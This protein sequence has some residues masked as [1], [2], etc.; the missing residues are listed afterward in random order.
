MGHFHDLIADLRQPTRDLRGAIPDAM[1]G[2]GALHQGAMADGELS[3]ATKELM[4][5]AISVVL[6]CE[7]CIAYHAKGAVA[8]GATE[9][10]AAEAIGVALLMSGG[11]AT[12]YGPMA[13][14]AFRE[15]A[16]GE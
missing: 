3:T 1:K 16:A 6:H 15:F 5:L 9:A 4:A 8:A 14:Q 7:G 2:F 13:L 12:T 11:P 10:Q